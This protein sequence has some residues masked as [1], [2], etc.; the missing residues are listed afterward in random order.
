[1]YKSIFTDELGLDLAKAIPHLKEWGFTHCDLRSRIF[2]RPLESLSDE[3]LYEVKTLLEDNGLKVGCLQ[4]AFG[5]VHLPDK[6]GLAEQ[7]RKLERIIRASEI[8]DCRLVRSFFFWQ[9]PNGQQ[10]KQGEVAVRPDVLAKVM[11]LF[12]PFAERAKEAGLILAFENCGCTKEE[13]FTMLDAL[14]VPE[15]G[16][17]WDPKNTWMAD[18]EAREADFEG[19]LKRLA[20]RTI[21]VHVKSIGTISDD[22]GNAELIPYDKVFKAC[23]A[24]GFNGPV[25]LETHN[26][27]PSISHVEA[28]RRVLEVV[29]RAWPSAA[30][31]AQ[32]E[33][34]N[35]SAE[36]LNR[37]WAVDPV[38]FA[39]VG[40]GMGHN[41][42]QEIAKTSGLKLVAVCDL[43]DKRAQ[44]TGETCG[45]PYET[46]FSKCLS[47]PDVEAVMVLNETGRHAELVCQALDAGKHVLVTKPMEITNEACEKM[48]EAAERNERVLAVDF[49]RR[50]RPSVQSLRQAARSGFFGKPLSAHVSLRVNRSDG[51]F[52]ERGG[53]RG[54][55]AL[56]GGVLSNQ[57]VHHLDEL[58]YCFGMPERVRCDTYLQN[59]DIE[60]EDLG[61]AVWEYASGLVVNLYA[62]TC[63]PQETWYYQMEIHGT[64]G[65]YLH[66]E[67]GP[68]SAPETRWLHG[69][70]WSEDA[71]ET[72]YCEY[73]NSMDNFAAHL[74]DGSPLLATA[75]DGHNTTAVI[76]AMYESAYEQNGGWV[77]L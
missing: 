19:Y 50:V 60:M 24:E 49:C 17:A 72:V 69:K 56:D 31:G 5:K 67:G 27:D 63:F 7:M 64:D 26:F 52:L 68:M 20:E 39:V 15:W 16:F 34:S 32:Q 51:Y 46:D 21:C 58:I 73:L 40:L 43:D 42:A 59:H 41:R 62:T 25:S 35:V 2:Q 55:K 14:D 29:D 11:D 71:P 3:Q 30:A 65:A 9:P 38:K 12:L 48:M 75:K 28:C 8:L 6:E 18:K 54:T 22:N 4:S 36:E 44:R 57:T 70:S 33:T 74:R 37:P 13:C 76:A 23:L 66:R 10:E 53:W 45:V 47:N 77:A 61:I 1:M